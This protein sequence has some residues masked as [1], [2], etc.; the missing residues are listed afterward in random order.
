[1]TGA[2]E[3]MWRLAFEVRRLLNEA[4]HLDVPAEEAIAKMHLQLEQLR[5]DNGHQRAQIDNAKALIARLAAH[6]PKNGSAA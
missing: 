4:G 5:R 1:M 6:A 2:D 3:A